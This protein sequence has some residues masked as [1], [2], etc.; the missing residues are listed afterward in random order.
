MSDMIKSTTL[1]NGLRIITDYTPSMH[2]VGVG[3]WAGVG[4]RHENLKYNGN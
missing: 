2:S 1:D 4:T 3:V